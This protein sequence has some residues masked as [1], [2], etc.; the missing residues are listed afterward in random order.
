MLQP[1]AD[2]TI[3]ARL[4]TLCSCHSCG[5]PKNLQ[6]HFYEPSMQIFINRLNFL[7]IL[8]LLL[9]PSFEGQ[10]KYP[11]LSLHHLFWGIFLLDTKIHS[12]CDPLPSQFFLQQT[13]T[14]HAM[15][16]EAHYLA[17]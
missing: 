2:M 16:V 13:T 9:T 17:V 1:N 3:I 10:Q 7:Q 8:N 11:L 15:V 12:H 6:Q 4:P 14:T 5:Y